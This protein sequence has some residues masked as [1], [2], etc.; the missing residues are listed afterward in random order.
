MHVRH[1][2]R[3]FTHL[4]ERQNSPHTILVFLVDICCPVARICPFSRKIDKEEKKSITFSEYPRKV[5]VFT[6]ECQFLLQIT[7]LYKWGRFVVHCTTLDSGVSLFYRVPVCIAESGCTTEDQFAHQFVPQSTSS[8]YT[9]R[10]VLHSPVCTTEFQFVLQSTS[11]CYRVPICT[12]ESQAVVQTTSLCYRVPVC[13]TD[14]FVLQSTNFKGLWEA[15]PGP[16]KAPRGI[17]KAQWPQHKD[18]KGLVRRS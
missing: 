2:R 16:Y 3:A 1:V 14:Q 10:F 15:F 6:T 11:A 8:H 5:T 9:V 17:Y 4:S 7:S 12:A 13:T 18:H